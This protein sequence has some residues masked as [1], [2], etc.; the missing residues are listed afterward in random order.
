MLSA[1]LDSDERA[2]PDPKRQNRHARVYV[3]RAP[4]SRA[5]YLRNRLARDRKRVATKR[6]GF[7]KQFMES[8]TIH[9]PP[10]VF[11]ETTAP[12]AGPSAGPSSSARATP[13]PGPST[14]ASEHDGTHFDLNMLD[15]EF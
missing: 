10:F 5:T 3:A 12:Q 4:K 9:D 2:D 11:E 15:E 1:F 14:E 6:D 7:E 13:Q 8:M